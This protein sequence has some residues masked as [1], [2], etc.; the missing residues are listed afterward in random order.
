VNIPQIIATIC[1]L[2]EHWEGPLCDKNLREWALGCALRM[3]FMVFVSAAIYF[4]RFYENQQHMQDRPFPFS[5]NVG[6]M[7][8]KCKYC[9][10]MLGLA[11]FVIGNMWVF[12]TKTCAVAI[13]AVY[14]LCL[15]MVLIGHAMIF[16]P[17]IVVILVLPLLCFCLPCIVRVLARLRDPMHGKG[18]AAEAIDKL[19]TI[20][21][22]PKDG[23][24]DQ[25]DQNEN[26]CAI[27]LSDFEAGE[28]LRLLPC[29]HRFHKTCV[30]E[31]LRVNASC[32]TC[33][34]NIVADV[35][36]EVANPVSGGTAEEDG[37]RELADLENPRDSTSNQVVVI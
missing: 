4:G 21:F 14:H 22:S 11:W 6:V 32:P 31:W 16:L 36:T 24:G 37:G 30:D 20:T 9:L 17:C 18:A 5:Q 28:E 12:T 26:C 3:L 13:P 29:S 19:E 34:Q 10:D 35:Q 25:K 27:C 15:A 8:Y 2:S 7:L 23:D 33:R 1:V